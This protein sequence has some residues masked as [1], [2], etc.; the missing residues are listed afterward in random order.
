MVATFLTGLFIFALLFAINSATH[1]YL[2]VR[3]AMQK[4]LKGFSASGISASF[5]LPFE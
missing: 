3:C 4:Y 2:I 5:E 1:S